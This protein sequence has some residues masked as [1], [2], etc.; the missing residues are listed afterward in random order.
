MSVPS[1]IVAVPEVHGCN[2]PSNP[3]KSDSAPDTVVRGP[4][5]VTDER[6]AYDQGG[7]AKQA[8][9]RGA[10]NIDHG[11][12]D[13]GELRADGGREV[14]DRRADLKVFEGWMRHST[15][16]GLT[17]DEERKEILRPGPFM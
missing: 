10:Q 3:R 13:F 17:G 12:N 14:V 11:P 15:R 5:P 9:G 7:Q 4:E 1:I 16:R 6:H 8:H 2:R